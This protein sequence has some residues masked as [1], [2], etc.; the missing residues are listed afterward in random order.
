[1]AELE[2]ATIGSGA[3]A[4]L[5]LLWEWKHSVIFPIHKK[6][7]SWIALI[8]EALAPC[9]IAVRSSLPLSCKE[10]RTEQRNS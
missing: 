10:S 8:T 2:A 5:I 9:A 4:L 7:T 6:R 3:E 1:M